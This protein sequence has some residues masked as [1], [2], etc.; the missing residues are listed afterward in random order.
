MPTWTKKQFHLRR[1]QLRLPLIIAYRA[2]HW[3]KF[4]FLVGKLVNFKSLSIRIRFAKRINIR[5]FAIHV[6]LSFIFTQL[7]ARSIAHSSCF[8]FRLNVSRSSLQDTRF[9]SMTYYHIFFPGIFFHESCLDRSE[10]NKRLKITLSSFT[11]RYLEKSY[12]DKKRLKG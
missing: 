11:R 1:K 8:P 10:D 5:I 9:N 7:K 3:P 2:F 6:S 4:Q 12:G